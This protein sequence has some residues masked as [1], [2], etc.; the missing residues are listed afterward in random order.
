MP[1]DQHHAA[2]DSGVEIPALADGEVWA[3]G[4]V[5]LNQ[6]GR[7]FAQKRSPDRRLFPDCWDIVGGHVEPGE[8]LLD[9]LAR[10]VAEETGW[11]LCRVRRLLGVATWTG[12]DGNGTRHEADYLVEVEGDLDHPALEWSKHTAYD[13]FGPDD[14]SRLK[15][16]RAPGEYLIHDLIAKAL[17]DRTG[18]L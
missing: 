14:L 3:V 11:R 10:E 7:A 9:A 5:I 18:R 17:Q 4:A 8:S 15:E 2:V 6:H 13:W 16:N 1:D 12:D